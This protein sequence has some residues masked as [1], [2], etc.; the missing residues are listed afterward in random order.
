MH[1]VRLLHTPPA[2][3]KN[4]SVGALLLMG[5]VT[6][7]QQTSRVAMGLL[8]TAP[9]T[10]AASSGVGVGGTVVLGEPRAQ[11][12]GGAVAYATVQ[13]DLG[14][15][16]Q[17]GER[18]FL[19]GRASLASSSLGV[20]Q[21]RTGLDITPSAVALDTVVSTAIDIP[22]N[23]HFGLMPAFDLGLQW[24]PLQS[25]PFTLSPLNVL[26]SFRGGLA[27]WTT[28]DRLRVFFG[29]TLATGV[30]NDPIGRLSTD[31]QPDPMTGGMMCSTTETGVVAATAVA[32]L[33]AG[34]RFQFLPE[35]SLTAELWVPVSRVGTQLPPMLTITG[36]FGDFRVARKRAKMVNIPPPPLF[37]EPPP[38]PPPAPPAEPISL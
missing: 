30:W 18:W 11:R 4:L 27:A 32:M 1:E 7:S 38:P 17:I 22:L 33:G 36:R 20:L 16:F 14:V 6:G 10:F 13:P 35:V 5:C 21:P 2:R 34:A 28:W 3:M 15:L 26:P 19:G 25:Q 23:A 12:Q 8:P 29:G 31:C 37:Q 24:I 9:Q